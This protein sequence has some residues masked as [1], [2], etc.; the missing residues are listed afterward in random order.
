MKKMF[1]VHR[2]SI[3]HGSLIGGRWVFWANLWILKCKVR[4]TIS[5]MQLM[6]ASNLW[7]L[8]VCKVK[9][10]MTLIHRTKGNLKK[11]PRSRVQWNWTFLLIKSFKLVPRLLDNG[12]G[13]RQIRMWFYLHGIILEGKLIGLDPKK[14]D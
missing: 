4:P 13:L 1:F 12:L 6:D 10:V 5:N 9:V 7:M 14:K 3:L 8:I 2:S 11:S